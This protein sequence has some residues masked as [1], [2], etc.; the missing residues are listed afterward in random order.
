ML[1]PVTAEKCLHANLRLLRRLVQAAEVWAL[2]TGQRFG[3]QTASSSVLAILVVLYIAMSRKA[4]SVAMFDVFVRLPIFLVPFVALRRT[5]RLLMTRLQR[6]MFAAE[7]LGEH[8]WLSGGD[9]SVGFDQH[10]PTKTSKHVDPYVSDLLPTAALMIGRQGTQK[11]DFYVAVIRDYLKSVFRFSQGVGK[12]ALKYLVGVWLSVELGFYIWF[13]FKKR[14]LNKREHQFPLHSSNTKTRLELLMWWLDTLDRAALARLE[15]ASQ[16]EAETAPTLTSELHE[17]DSMRSSSLHDLREH[18]GIGVVSS[19]EELADAHGSSPRLVRAAPPPK[20]AS[21]ARLLLGQR[22]SVFDEGDNTNSST[23]GRFSKLAR[24]YSMADAFASVNNSVNTPTGASNATT[25]PLSKSGSFTKHMVR[26]QA[27]LD[28]SGSDGGPPLVIPGGGRSGLQS[29]NSRSHGRITPIAGSRSHAVVFPPQLTTSNDHGAA[30]GSTSSS[31]RTLQRRSKDFL[32]LRQTMSSKGVLLPSV[33]SKVDLQAYTCMMEREFKS[34]FDESQL[35]GIGRRGEDDLDLDDD[36]P[37]LDL[38]PREA[39]SRDASKESAGT[40]QQDVIERSPNAHNR[41]LGEQSDTGGPMSKKTAG[42]I[43]RPRNKNGELVHERTSVASNASALGT[44]LEFGPRSKNELTKQLTRMASMLPRASQV[45]VI[46]PARHVVSKSVL[47]WRDV[48]KLFIVQIRRALPFSLAIKVGDLSSGIIGVFKPLL[49]LL[50]NMNP[51]LSDDLVSV[52]TVDLEFAAS[53]YGQETQGMEAILHALEKEDNVMLLPT[54]LMDL[55]RAEF[56][57]WFTDDLVSNWADIYRPVDLRL[58]SRKDV[59][60]WVATHWFEARLLADIMRAS[61]EEY[62]ELKEMAKYVINW[63]EVGQILSKKKVK[64]WWNCYHDELPVL[65][66]PA[67]VYFTTTLVL[68]GVEKYLFSLD[69]QPERI[70]AKKAELL[71]LQRSRRNAEKE[72]SGSKRSAAKKNLSAL[73]AAE[74]L[75]QKSQSMLPAFVQSLVGFG[76]FEEKYRGTMRYFYRRATN[77]KAT[78]KRTS[79]VAFSSSTGGKMTK[80]REEDPEITTS[81]SPEKPSTHDQEYNLLHGAGGTS[82]SSSGMRTTNSR[83]VQ[84]AGQ[85]SMMPNSSSRTTLNIGTRVPSQATLDLTGNLATPSQPM[86]FSRQHTSEDGPSSLFGN[87]KQE[88]QQTFVENNNRPL[89][90]VLCHGLGVGLVGYGTMVR[91]MVETFGEEYDLFVLSEPWVSMRVYDAVPT[92]REVALAIMHVLDFHGYQSAHFVGHSYGTAICSWCVKH[93]PSM[94]KKL[95]LLDP[96]CFQTLKTALGT[97]SG[98]FREPGNIVDAVISY[99]AFRELFTVFAMSWIHWQDTELFPEVLPQG[100]TLVFLQE[101]DSIVPVQTVRGYLSEYEP[102]LKIVYNPGTFHACFLLP[103]FN[104]LLQTVLC[105]ILSL[106]EKPDHA[107]GGASAMNDAALLPGTSNNGGAG[108]EMQMNASSLNDF[109]LTLTSDLTIRSSGQDLSALYQQHAPVI[110]EEDDHVEEEIAH[111]LKVGHEHEEA[112]AD[113]SRATSK[114]YSEDDER[115]RERRT[116]ISSPR[117]VI[118]ISPP[119]GTTKPTLDSVLVQ[120]PPVSTPGSGFATNIVQQMSSPTESDSYSNSA[121]SD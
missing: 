108:V 15:A 91:G 69:F 102:L 113:L 75:A 98:T 76:G 96:V 2:R 32:Q 78:P 55:R 7:G 38:P 41:K 9:S 58:V 20:V 31:S 109:P 37:A 97:M 105:E 119:P 6:E 103:Q 13:Y 80:M 100:Q 28:T 60:E 19:A 90:L 68:P 27:S 14:G 120:P 93:A 111:L 74:E 51:L 26:R 54:S 43:A 29:T 36:V 65:Y 99:V 17:N 49:N 94:V 56:A 115:E 110:L 83:G 87:E 8:I 52:L 57:S 35:A 46:A 72:K 81:S 12:S 79:R 34:H 11:L 70:Q 63:A 3:F 16:H 106:H 10:V 25:R 47:A 39:R 112:I 40:R 21:R 18:S 101:N 88:E 117:N 73:V 71:V 66:R 121:A 61:P 24:S 5:V 44:A 85:S 116:K 114:N 53:G 84:L 33:C 30:V 82:M 45:S 89:P 50:I 86:R 118:L 42:P 95:T 107:F 22:L 23:V 104:Y 1:V 77:P 67:L 59:E 92:G 64:A 48:L 62:S 4:R